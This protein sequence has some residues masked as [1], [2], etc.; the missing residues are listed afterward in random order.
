[1]RNI[2][3]Y[4][5]SSDYD[6]ALSIIF[7]KFPDHSKEDILKDVNK[8]YE[9]ILKDNDKLESNNDELK[10]GND[11][12]KPEN[13]ELKPGKDELEPSNLEKKEYSN[14]FFSTNEAKEL[15]KEITVENVRG[16]RQF[17]KRFKELFR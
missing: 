6:K 2:I 12:L 16:W 9:A 1:M 4:A 3:S 15:R 11:E 5:Y 17:L 7:E 8:Q 13:D 14:V 10:P